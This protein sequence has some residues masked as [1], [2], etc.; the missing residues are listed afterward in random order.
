MALLCLIP[1]IG[2]TLRVNGAARLT[3]NPELLESFALGGK[4]PG[5]V[6]LVTL[7]R[8]YFQCQKALARPRLWPAEAQVP[9]GELPSAG[10]ILQALMTE[11]FD[12]QAYDKD[13]PAGPKETIH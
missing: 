4:P 10:E 2:E 3:V 5:S 13:H 9:R 6:I 8:L 1:G 7:E 11:P 12:G